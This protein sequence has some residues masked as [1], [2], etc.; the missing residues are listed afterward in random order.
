MSKGF[1]PNFDQINISHRRPCSVWIVNLLTWQNALEGG[2]DEKSWEM[3]YN[4]L[5]M[6]SSGDNNWP[7]GTSSA[8]VWIYLPTKRKK[9]NKPK[10][11][12]EATQPMAAWLK[13]MFYGFEYNNSI[14]STMNSTFKRCVWM[15]LFCH[16]EK[17][18]LTR[19]A[20]VYV[21]DSRKS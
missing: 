13:N 11:E 18:Q 9:N 2:Y 19:L 15:K 3:A 4:W 14:R 12:Q 8:E 21:L 5:M 1:W 7:S 20:N 17:K 6:T 10:A 16:S